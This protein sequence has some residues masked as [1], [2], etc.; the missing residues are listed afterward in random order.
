MIARLG[1]LRPSQKSSLKTG[2]AIARVLVAPAASYIRSGASSPRPWPLL[3]MVDTGASLSAIDA[4][5]ARAMGLPQ[6][7]TSRVA[8]ATGVAN[9][10]VHAASVVL[11]D[12]G[13]RFDPVRLAGI[14]LQGTGFHLLLGRDILSDLNLDYRGPAGS[15]AL[16]M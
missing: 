10:P 16:R 9:L 15:F 1:Q 5:V 13:A 7:G 6:T 12:A 8:G 3:A 14:A 2:G 11:R 4:S